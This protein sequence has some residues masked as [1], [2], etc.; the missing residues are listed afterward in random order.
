MLFSTLGIFGQEPLDQQIVADLQ[1]NSQYAFVLTE[2]RHFK[3]VLEMY[4]RL[5]AN[6][7]GVTDYEIVTKGKVVTELV[8]GSELEAFYQKYKSKVRVSVCSVAMEIL[9][10]PAEE[11]FDG[12]EVVP[13]ASIRMLQL[14][15]RGYNTLTY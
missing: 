10:V 4:D 13:T 5:V 1:N 8:R 3:S 6:G 2:T 9:N 15:A 7:I 12:L 11:L 14:Q